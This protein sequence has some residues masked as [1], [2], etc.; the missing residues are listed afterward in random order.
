VFDGGYCV[1]GDTDCTGLVDADGDFGVAP[2]VANWKNL[3]CGCDNPAALTYCQDPDEDGLGNGEAGIEYCLEDIPNNTSPVLPATG[4][5]NNCDEDMGEWNC[6]T[7]NTD[8]CGVCAGN[9][10]IYCYAD[11][12]VCTENNECQ[13]DYCD[14]CGVCAGN[15]PIYCYADAEVCTEN[16]ECQADYCDACG[17]CMENFD[18]QS[19]YYE[20]WAGMEGS[21]GLCGDQPPRK[22][23][24]DDL[25]I[26][27]TILPYQPNVHNNSFDNQNFPYKH[28]RHHNNPLDIH[29]FQYKLQHQHS[30]KLDYY[31]H[32]HR[33]HH[34]NPLDIHYFQYKLQHQHSNKLDYYQHKHR[35]HPYYWLGS[36]IL[37]YL[38]HNYLPNLLLEELEMYCLEYPLNNILY[39]PH[40]YLDHLHQDLDSR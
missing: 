24:A 35:R 14:A 12:E 39:L 33:R 3:G 31:Q 2:C 20:H 23:K 28:R 30:N 26:N 13:A 5:V 37:P 15:N 1:G 9:N 11:A 18:C 38:H 40:H 17:V 7:N 25:H 27:R 32:K 29:Y 8:A 10:P 22:N 19:Y 36:S 21:Y 34:N 16:N 6:P 4:W